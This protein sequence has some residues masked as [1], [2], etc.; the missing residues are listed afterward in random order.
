MIV[1]CQR[2]LL[3]DAVEMVKFF[4]TPLPSSR[5][6]K[7]YVNVEILIQPKIYLTAALFRL[8]MCER[9]SVVLSL[10]LVKEKTFQKS[11]NR[12]IWF[13]PE[14]PP[15]A[16]IGTSHGGLRETSPRLWLPPAPPPRNFSWRTLCHGLVH[17]DYC[18]IPRGYR[19]VSLFSLL[20]PVIL[21]TV[22][23]IQYWVYG[24]WNGTVIN[25]S[26]SS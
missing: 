23:F 6:I 2:I 16:K 20:V 18:S 12:I 5:P 24:K 8:H 17:G 7:K 11:K 10:V 15:P 9:L 3:L 13:E 14:Y 19:L 4:K 22:Y 21:N 25:P 1:L 26:T